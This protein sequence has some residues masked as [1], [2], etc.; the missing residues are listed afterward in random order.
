MTHAEVG[1]H[2]LALWGLPHNVIE[3]VAG[4]H[5]PQWLKLPF[6]GVAAIQIANVLV[7]QVESERLLSPFTPSELDFEYLDEAGLTSRLAGWRELAVRQFDES[8]A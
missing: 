6:D 2:L 3:V 8:L 1:A 4:H 7:E 5:N